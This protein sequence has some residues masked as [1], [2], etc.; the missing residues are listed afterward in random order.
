MASV[1]Q[2]TP[3]QTNGG[4]ATATIGVENPA[5]GE[6]ITT[7]PVL[8]ADEIARDGEAR[9]GGAARLGRDWDSR[10]AA[11][12]CAG[13]RS[14]CSTTPTASSTSSSPR[15]GKTHED[16]QLAD[17]GYTVERARLLGQGGARSTSPTS[18]CRRGTTRSRPA[19][20]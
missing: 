2:Q 10:S 4:S 3:V 16:A 11:A 15:A 13:R 9:P 8:G 12:S 7:I 1:E 5:T 19:R 18:G 6:L 20:S 17:L 14:G